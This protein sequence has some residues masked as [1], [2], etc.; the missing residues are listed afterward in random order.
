MAAV[1][2]LRVLYREPPGE[3]LVSTAM[4]WKGA[5]SVAHESRQPVL[6]EPLCHTPRAPVGSFRHPSHA[7]VRVC[8]I[9]P[10]LP[11]VHRIAG[12]VSAAIPSKRFK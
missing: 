12:S 11:S 6:P 9:S 5:V 4:V 3:S 7:P 1:C 8:P 2:Q 10:A